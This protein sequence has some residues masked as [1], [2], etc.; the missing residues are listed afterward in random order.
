MLRNEKE[1]LK[2]LKWLSKAITA[3]IWFS[4]GVQADVIIAEHIN[5]CKCVEQTS[6]NM[7]HK[8]SEQALKS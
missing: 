7:H 2:L 6:Y 1:T 3:I 8:T 5:V 4:G